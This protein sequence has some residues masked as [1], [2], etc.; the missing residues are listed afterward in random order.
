MSLTRA[1]VLSCICN[2]EGLASLTLLTV[3]RM[4]LWQLLQQSSAIVN[5]NG[6][7]FFL[8]PGVWSSDAARLHNGKNTITVNTTLTTAQPYGV[9]IRSDKVESFDGLTLS[10]RP[11]RLK[12][13]NGELTQADVGECSWYMAEQHVRW[14]QQAHPG[15]D[16]S[17][18]FGWKVDLMSTKTARLGL[19]SRMQRTMLHRLM[20]LG[21]S[22]DL[23]DACF[24]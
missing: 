7:S 12:S 22:F 20:R 4:K 18:K 2:G 19:T 24:Q 6:M 21:Q 9:I 15:N 16:V 8:S 3:L 1:R 10:Y 5:I 17:L 14:R 13:A 23:L 11:N